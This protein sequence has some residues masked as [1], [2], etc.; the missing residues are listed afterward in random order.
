M[1]AFLWGHPGNSRDDK[2]NSPAASGGADSNDRP[3]RLSAGHLFEPGGV[4]HRF[5]AV[6][7]GIVAGPAGLVYRV[8]LQEGHAALPG[9]RDR[10]FEKRP[11]HALATI[12]RWHDEADD[13]P[14]GPPVDRLH[15]GR[16][17]QLRVVISWTKR[18][19]ADRN[20]ASIPDETRRFARA[21]QCLELGAVR[22]C[23]RGPCPQGAARTAAAVVH[24]PARPPDRT[25]PAV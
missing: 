22:L 21:E 24:A 1:L 12:L 18:N 20:L 14:D 25:P 19:P 2:P 23:A 8:R 4:V 9:I 15:H 7:H 6:P 3:I 16:A 17:P 11:C 5:R 10:S 13:R